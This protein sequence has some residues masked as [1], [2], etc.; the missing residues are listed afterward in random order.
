MNKINKT[1]KVILILLT[2]SISTTITNIDQNTTTE[3][4]NFLSNKTQQENLNLKPN[5]AF[6]EELD[7][8]NPFSDINDATPYKD[9]ILWLNENGVLNGYLDGE[10]KPD[11]CVSRAEFLKI[12]FFTNELTEE[13]YTEGMKEYHLYNDVQHG[14]WYTDYVS[15]YT[16]R[17]VIEGYQDGTFQPDKC[18]DKAEAIKMAVEDF[19]LLTEKPEEKNKYE[20]IKTSAWFSKYIHSALNKNLVGTGHITML[21]N[22]KYFHPNDEMSRK[23]VSALLFRMKTIK[24]NKSNEFTAEQ[25][26]KQVSSE[27]LTRK[28]SDYKPEVEKGE[29]IELKWPYEK[30]ENYIY[31][32]GEV[33]EA[34]DLNTFE[35]IDIGTEIIQYAKD[36]NHIYKHGEILTW[37]DPATFELLHDYHGQTRFI[38]IYE[39]DANNIY[40]R[41]KKIEA[42]N[43]TTFQIL[44][45]PYAKDK[46]NVYMDGEIVENID[47]TT[48][49]ALQDSYATDKNAVYYNGSPFENS[50]PSSFEVLEYPCAKD[51]NNV[52]YLG[53]IFEGVDVETFEVIEYLY[54]KD[55]NNVYHYNI[56]IEGANPKTFVVPE[57]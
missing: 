34:G 12:L 54:S 57:E 46:N 6:A 2:I 53:N 15:F 20:D 49:I 31:M 33:F 36:K 50:D 13:Q 23:E 21:N 42:A 25:K 39:K 44:T 48:F 17:G 14:S 11:K 1:W 51:K 32:Y 7:I 22:Q 5:T 3:V 18:L 38:T 27:S 9:E 43:P 37:A 4:N 28:L 56:I 45:W 30:D 10:F 35:I 26:A 41:D 24:D 47:A 19:K 40:F 52:Y 55:K 29:I 8:V 16:S